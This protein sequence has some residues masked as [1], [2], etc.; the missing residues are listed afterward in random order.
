MPSIGITATDNITSGDYFQITNISSLGFT[1]HFKDSSNASI[2][3][4]FN[5]TAVG[6]GKGA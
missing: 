6:F 2:N 5:F 1:V 3:R 4:N